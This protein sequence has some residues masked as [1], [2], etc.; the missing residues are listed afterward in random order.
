[1]AETDTRPMGWQFFSRRDRDET[2][3]HRDHNPGI[4]TSL[5]S[6]LSHTVCFICLWLVLTSDWILQR[7]QVSRFWHETL[8]FRCPLRPPILPHCCFWHFCCSANPSTVVFESKL[9]NSTILH[10][11][12]YLKLHY[13]C[14]SYLLHNRQLWSDL[15]HTQV[16][17]CKSL[18]R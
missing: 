15:V 9:K 12:R 18:N 2:L 4:Y 16:L 1:M 14:S 5:S 10:V 11:I 13:L 17:L 3:V 6:C 7:C 8:I